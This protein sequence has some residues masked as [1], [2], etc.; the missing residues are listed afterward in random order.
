MGRCCL[1][2]G[3]AINEV[4]F[5]NCTLAGTPRYRIVPLCLLRVAFERC[6]QVEY[7]TGHYTLHT[8]GQPV[9]GSMEA[10]VQGRD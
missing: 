6:K 9:L 5:N 4:V 8:H 10:R 1:G 2:S 7:M 3:T